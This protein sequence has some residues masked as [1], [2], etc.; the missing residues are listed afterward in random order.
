[1]KKDLFKM[2]KTFINVQKLLKKVQIVKKSRTMRPH[3]Q[4]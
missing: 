1:M 2:M 3:L 4:Q